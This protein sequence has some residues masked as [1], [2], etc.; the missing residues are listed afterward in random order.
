[1]RKTFKVTKPDR[2]FGTFLSLVIL[3]M[4][5]SF[6]AIGS[7]PEPTISVYFDEAHTIRS[8]D[9]PGPGL[10][11]L[12]VV[13]EDFNTFL[14]G[15]D[16]K[17]ILPPSLIW[18]ADLDTPPATVGTTITGITLGFPVPLNGFA[19]LQILSMLVLWNCV[20]CS[21][22][23]QEIQV[24]EN[25]TTMDL[26]GVRWPDFVK[27]DA[28]G[29]ISLVCESLNQPPVADAGGPYE[30][31][32]AGPGGAEVTLDGTAS[33]DP[34]GD[35]I[36]FSWSA[37]GVI[38]DDASSP[39]PK[40]T[41]PLGTTTVTLIVDDGNG[42]TSIDETEVTV[43]E[44]TAPPTITI[45]LSRDV[46]WPPNHKMV[47]IWADVTVTDNCDDDPEWY[48]LSVESSEPDNG[49]G[50]GN[51]VDDIQGAN[52][53]TQDEHFELRSERQGGGDGRKYTIT[54][55]AED[56]AGNVAV[57]EACVRVPHDHSGVALASTGFAAGGTAF[58]ESYDRFAFVIPSQ[59]D[60]FAMDVNGNLI[61]LQKAFDATAIDPR[62]VYVGNTK[63][64]VR[65]D[66]TLELDVNGDGLNDLA[67]YYP[68]EAVLEIQA[69][70]TAEEQNHEQVRKD[71][72]HGPI[73]V[74][75]KGSD[76]VD[77]LVSDLF[78]LGDP[79]PLLP[80][81]PPMPQF[82]DDAPDLTKATGLTSIYP[83][84]FNPTTTV[85]FYLEHSSSVL[86]RVYDTR[87]A[88][89]RTLRDERLPAGEHQVEWNGRDDQGH[90]VAT[91]VYFARLVAGRHRSSQK[92]VM[93]K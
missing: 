70:L 38:F 53:G 92:M 75:Y 20:D 17:V 74:H 90:V 25:P 52:V 39:T 76:E 26:V 64:A 86:L 91:G 6:S 18:L 31:D 54:Y 41:F 66:E 77:Y 50:D 48:L 12:Y 14:S 16:F 51:T 21:S 32:C 93:V 67:L 71:A 33:S 82:A 11:T 36:S 23:N 24:V 81:L 7:P 63:G 8:K 62:D 57:V 49:K 43:T 73:G 34:D 88:L 2:R 29:G 15:F 80:S 9:C 56:A 79:V 72:S 45:A 4:V 69:Q 44:D 5:V 47:E 58:D 68:V 28:V 3:T 83:N 89:V 22:N 27:I 40:A 46:L 59:P 37:P 65:P 35:P 30:A 1:M 42:G 10:D 19:P 55:T 61:R 85:G 78:S 60:K 13:A 84:P 87:G